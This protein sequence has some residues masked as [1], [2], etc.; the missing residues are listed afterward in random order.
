MGGWVGR[1]RRNVVPAWPGVAV[2]KGISFQE[3]VLVSHDLLKW[4][5]VDCPKQ[6][7]NTHQ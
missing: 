2:K 3:I 4:L 6:E 1:K 5:S 7:G